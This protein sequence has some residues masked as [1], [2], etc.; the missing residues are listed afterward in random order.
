M[1]YQT[2]RP[3]LIGA[4]FALVAS[5]SAF[6]AGNDESPASG[7]GE[8]NIYSHRHYSTDDE[9]YRLFE[10]ETG[11]SVNILQASADELIARLEREGDASPADILFTV[12]AGR[13]GRA[14]DLGLLQPIES[15]Q[16]ARNVPPHLRDSDGYWYGLTRRAR[17]IVYH[18]DRVDAADLSTYEALTDPEWRGR[19]LIRSSSNI[20]NQSL[21]ASMIANDGQAAARTWAAGM[22]DNMARTPAGGDTD[23]IKAVAA[24][25]GDVA[26]VNTYYV[27]RLQASESAEDRSVAEAVGVFFPNQDG[28]GAH[29]NVSG[30]GVTA[31]APNRANAIRLLEFLSGTEAQ[32]LYATANHEYPVHA[33]VAADP[34]LAGWG[35]FVSDDLGL[36]ILGELNSDATRIFDEVGWR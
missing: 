2:G 35:E 1:S 3:A 34:A 24:G 14:K 5:M 19:V 30:A 17:V 6:G 29:V 7:G 18:K 15:P 28:R 31:H 21:L 8:V 22:V 33:N 12:D 32:Y 4:V 16:L 10:E 9:L 13:L 27:G 20:Y 11:I 25:E 26:I 36:Q 23:Q